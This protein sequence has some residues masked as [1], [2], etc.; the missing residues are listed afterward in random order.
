MIRESN[1]PIIRDEHPIKAFE[2]GGFSLA[3]PGVKPPLEV[4]VNKLHVVN[5]ATKATHH[6]PVQAMV[7]FVT[8]LVNDVKIATYHPRTGTGAPN[9]AQFIKEL[10]PLTVS[11]RP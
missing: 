6:T 5:K 3:G 7:I 10:N 8:S 4:E 11:L 2:R 1:C 9:C